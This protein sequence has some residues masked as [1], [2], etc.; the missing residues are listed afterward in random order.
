MRLDP[1]R[2]TLTARRVAIV[3]RREIRDQFR[4]WRIFTPIVILTVVFPSLMTFT[5]ER[6]IAYVNSTGGTL[7]S[8]RLAPFLMM[9]VGFFPIKLPE[10]SASPC[11]VVAFLE[12]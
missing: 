6:M 1:R 2:L 4:D 12:D 11:R 5:A 3:I 7:D 10:T 9:V 8:E